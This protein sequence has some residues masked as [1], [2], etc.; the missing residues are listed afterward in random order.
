MSSKKIAA[1]LW[2]RRDLRTGDNPA[3][4]HAAKHGLPVVP[5]YFLSHWQGNHAWTGPKRQHFLCGCLEALARD[6]ES[7]GG[8]LIIRQEEAIAGLRRLIIECRAVAVHFNMDPSPNSRLAESRLRQMC[9]ELGVEC[10]AHDD[11]TLLM[12]D[13]VL[14]QIHNPTGYSPPIAAHG[15]RCLSPGPLAEWKD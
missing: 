15:L 12:P 1:I 6:L 10:H 7:L 14:T 4:I 11:V 3:L 13:W 9:M 5:V 2:Y 8:R